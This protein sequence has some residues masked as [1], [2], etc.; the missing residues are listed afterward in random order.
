MKADLLKAIDQSAGV[1][2]DWKHNKD[3][4]QTATV[5]AERRLAEAEDRRIALALEANLGNAAAIAGIAKARTGHSAA[6]ADLQ[7]LGVALIDVE[8]RVVEAEGAAKAARNNLAK[9]ETAALIAERVEVAGEIDVAVAKLSLLFASYEKLGA[10][11]S[12]SETTARNLHGMVANHEGIV[13]LRRVA[14][15]LPV[16]F[17]KLFP[18]AHHDEMPKRPLK[19]QETQFW[20]ISPPEQ[21]SEAA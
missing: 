7:D 15:S 8:K 19:A 14:A 20:G 11:I 10:E 18:G 2:R 5:N 6:A 12:N 21:T 9:F 1:V 16:C 4:L 3:R 13:G 17:K